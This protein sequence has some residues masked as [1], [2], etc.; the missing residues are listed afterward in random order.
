[1]YYTSA[2]RDEDVFADAQAFDIRR[3]PNPHLSFGIAE[4]YCLGVHVARLEG[5]VFFEELLATYPTIELT[6]D[7][8][9]VRSN[10]NNALKVLPIQL[11]RNP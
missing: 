10:L 4:H 1:M 2:N 6:G 7:P 5:R 9:R 3:S 8:V 11:G